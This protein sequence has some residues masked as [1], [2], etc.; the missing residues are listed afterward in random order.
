MSKTNIPATRL[1][2]R[3]FINLGIFTVIFIVLFMVCIMVMSMTVYTQPFGAAEGKNT[4]DGRNPYFRH[5][6]RIGY[7]RYGKRLA[8]SCFC[9]NWNSPC[10]T[11][12]PEQ[13]IHKLYS[14]EHRLCGPDGVYRYRLLCAAAHHERLLFPARRHEQY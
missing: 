4:K 14:R 3:D 13:K 7:V 6:V 9:C 10:G 1:K 2:G 5:P 12:C 11:D 8:N